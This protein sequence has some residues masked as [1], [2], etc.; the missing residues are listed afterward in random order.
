MRETDIII[1]Y[2]DFSP[3][4]HISFTNIKALAIAQNESSH[5]KLNV[6]E[7]RFSCVFKE[8]MSGPA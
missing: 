1:T 8:I 5:F 6:T 2:S 7:K 4:F 3:A